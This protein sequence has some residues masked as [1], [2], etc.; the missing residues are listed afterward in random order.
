MARKIAPRI[1]AWFLALLFSPVSAYA[2]M[3]HFDFDS[4]QSARKKQSA[5]PAIEAYMEGLS[6]YDISVSFNTAVVRG[7]SITI[8][9][10]AL[11]LAST[12][13]DGDAYLTPG[14]GKGAAI[15]TIDFGDNPIDSFS[16]DF[17]LFKK[18]KKFAIVADGV[19][20]DQESLSKA[21]RK[22]GLRGQTILFFDEPVEKLQFIGSKKKSIGIDNLVINLP[23][24]F[25]SSLSLTTPSSAGFTANEL[26]FNQ[27]FAAEAL[28]LNQLIAAE[29][30]E[31]STLWL[32]ASGAG[33]IWSTLRRR[34]SAQKN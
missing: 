13:G 23:H 27:S 1:P 5:A 14:K 19:V 10:A 9:N 20:V 16:V 7:R 33:L 29:V 30:P 2:D 24:D 22:T 25:A 3:V 31:P 12:A 26:E 34:L 32:F 17:Q 15:I 11:N 8:P 21:Q 6:G 4:I 18:A 28:E